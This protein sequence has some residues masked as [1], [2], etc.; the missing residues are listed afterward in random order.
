[1]G[2][3]DHIRPQSQTVDKPVAPRTRKSHT[4][5]TRHQEGKKNKNNQLSFPHQDDCKT[6]FG[7]KV[8]NKKHRTITE[9]LN[10]SNNQPRIAKFACA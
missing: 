1:M 9:S 4:T 8:S 5:I 2:E 6:S 7:H 3:Y 10:G